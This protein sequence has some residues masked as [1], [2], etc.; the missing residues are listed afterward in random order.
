MVSQLK[1]PTDKMFKKRCTLKI[2]SIQMQQHPLSVYDKY[3]ITYQ[4]SPN[5]AL[6]VS[7]SSTE[8]FLLL[9]FFPFTFL[10]FFDVS[11]DALNSY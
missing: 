7:S 3:L 10:V 1:L 9:P 5:V 11:Q 4:V 8:S 2:K 6:G